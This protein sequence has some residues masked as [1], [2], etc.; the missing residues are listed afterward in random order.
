MKHQAEP[1]IHKES[2][3]PRCCHLQR[4][5]SSGMSSVMGSMNHL[6][7]SALGPSQREK[8]PETGRGGGDNIG[9]PAGAGGVR[10][11]VVVGARAR[12]PGPRSPSPSPSPI[13]RGS[14]VHPH[15]HPRFPGDRGSIPTAIPDLPESGIQLS[16]MEH[17]K[18]IEFRLPQ[19]LTLS[20]RLLVQ[21]IK[22]IN[23]RR[24]AMSDVQFGG[25]CL[26]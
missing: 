6:Q 8:S 22:L 26:F 15:R 11:D 9:R 13:C 18:G 10:V 21:P 2:Q 4:V 25:G 12:N 3:T 1:Q 16:T 23:M 5:P 17:C 19:C 24:P 14:G 20:L 7:C